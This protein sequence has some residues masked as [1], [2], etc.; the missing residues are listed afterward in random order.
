MITRLSPAKVN[1][2]LKILRKREDGYHDLVTLMQP[3]SLCDE[4]SFLPVERGITLRCP[5]NTLPED[6]QNIVYRAAELMIH[7]TGWPGGVEIGLDKRIPL[8]AGLGG[9]SSNAATTLLVLNEIMGSPLSKADLMRAGAKLGADVPFFIHGRSAWASGIGDRLEEAPETPDLFFLLINPGFALSTKTV[10][11]N[12]NFALT[13]EPIHYSIPRFLDVQDVIKGL[14]NDLE[15]VSVKLHP[16]I[17]TLKTLLLG[18]GALGALMSGS[19][20]TVFGIFTSEEETI[21]A[22]NA[23]R[24]VSGWTHHRAHSL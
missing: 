9:G 13:K 23:L 21:Q 1:L 20:P 2:H 3:I 19:G 7:E 17:G 5:G 11:E 14:H 22:E 18:H 10:Y 15:R 12:L 6:R 24:K 16:V 8:A 4:M